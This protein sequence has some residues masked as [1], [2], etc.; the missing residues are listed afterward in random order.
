MYVLYIC[1]N[2]LSGS[3]YEVQRMW[4]LHRDLVEVGQGNHELRSEW[5]GTRSVHRDR[6]ISAVR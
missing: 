6:G 4:I 5:C 3:M 2:D 1:M